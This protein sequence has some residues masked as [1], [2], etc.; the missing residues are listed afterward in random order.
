MTMAEP[1]VSWSPKL[2]IKVDT[3]R[4][5]EAFTGL[6]TTIKKDVEEE[7]ITR[8]QFLDAL[9]DVGLH[10]TRGEREAIREADNET[11]GDFLALLIAKSI[12]DGVLEEVLEE[13]LDE[14][15]LP[16]HVKEIT[17]T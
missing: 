12:P 8:Q 2:E 14:P 10:L 6:C 17:H 11:F 7:M 15:A 5:D 1:S 4:F 13:I 3:Q 16:E 9:G